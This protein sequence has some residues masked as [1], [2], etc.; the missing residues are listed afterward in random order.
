MLSYARWVLVRKRQPGT[1]A[2]AEQV[3]DLPKAVLPEEL[4]EGCPPFELAGL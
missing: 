1:P 4:G 2:H 3:P